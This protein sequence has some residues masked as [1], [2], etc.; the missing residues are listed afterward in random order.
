MAE[1]PVG[2]IDLAVERAKL[3]EHERRVREEQLR[4]PELHMEK[5]T[6]LLIEQAEI[7][8]GGVEAWLSAVNEVL[9]EAFA[10]CA[11]DWFVT[12]DIQ[13][14]SRT[15]V[16]YNMVETLTDIVARAPDIHGLAS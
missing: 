1:Q 10:A 15:S 11:G 12:R 4:R 6:A 3:A 5:V 13:D 2:R 16:P 9:P 7:C 14:N 8:A